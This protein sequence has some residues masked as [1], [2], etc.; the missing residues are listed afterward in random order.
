[1]SRPRGRTADT[2]QLDLVRYELRRGDNGKVKIERLPMELLIFLVE[3]KGQLVTRAEV[4]ARLWRDGIFIDT[5]PA[6]NNAVRKIRLA[7]RDSPENPTHLETVVG[8][9]YRFIGDLDVIGA[10]SAPAASGPSTPLAAPAA[11]KDP[12]GEEITTRIERPARWKNYAPGGALGASVAAAVWFL[13]MRHRTDAPALR[14]TVLTSFVGHEG[15]PSLAPD[16]T[17]F[18]FSWDGD[19]PSGRQHVYISLL[20][21]GVPV[22]ITPE[23]ETGLMPAWSPDGQWVAFLRGRGDDQPAEASARP[24]GRIGFLRERTDNVFLELSVTPAIG[25][26]IRRIADGAVGDSISWSPD[27]R[28]LLFD[29]LVDPNHL[30]RVIHA[31]PAAGGEDRRLIDPSPGGGSG[32]T[33]PAISPDG[34]K[35]VFSRCVDDYDCDLFVTG[36]TDGGV[37][38]PLHQLTHDHSVKTNPHWTNDSNEVV[39][40]VG[41]TTSERS[42]FRVSGRGGEP[43]RIEGIG[44]N[45]THISLGSDARLLYSTSSINYDI[46][47]V[48]LRAANSAAAG[49]RFL[50]STRYEVAPSYSPDG[51]RISFSSNRG[52]IRQ[53]WVA[54]TDGS[55][56]SP[57][58]SFQNG[59]ASSPKWSPNGRYIVFDARPTANADIYVIAAEGG[60]PARLTD[61][62]GVDHVPTWSPDGNWIYFGSDRA[63]GHEIFRIRP[64]GGE[65]QQMTHNGGYY[66]VASADGKWLYYTVTRNGVWKM[67][68]E[69]GQATQVLPASAVMATF[70][71]AATRSGLYTVAAEQSQPDRFQILFHPFD[72]GKSEVLMALNRPPVMFPEVSPDEQWLLFTLADD[73]TDEILMVQ[74]FQ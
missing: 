55:N 68:A 41:E 40:I 64:R 15:S 52:G 23:N 28:W 57:L 20:G 69:G 49:E 13:A 45:A 66:G 16:G 6:I 24:G 72:A 22:R 46:R 29:R 56:P 1:M 65:V 31:V 47:R 14:P 44:Q 58:T 43:R 25:G 9:G 27:G 17:R 35:L 36:F 33:D 4:A 71:F 74:N 39:Y 3:R 62:P 26:P 63:G 5:E 30:Q 60:A 37:T 18:A 59:V 53:I 61:H 10:D 42:I 21:K 67:P 54:D 50:S 70:S 48:N 34:K 38:G 32:D 73:P 8:K 51:K 12:I 2:Y 7:L 11:A 19:L